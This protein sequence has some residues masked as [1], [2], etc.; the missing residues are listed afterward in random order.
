MSGQPRTSTVK[1]PAKGKRQTAKENRC[2]PKEKAGDAETP[3]PNRR[4]V[5]VP[6]LQVHLPPYQFNLID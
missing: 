2:R 4:K 6:P 3:R 5:P 1:T